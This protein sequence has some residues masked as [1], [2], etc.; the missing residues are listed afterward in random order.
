MNQAHELTRERVLEREGE[1]IRRVYNWMMAGLAV[2][3]GIAY[4]AAQSEAYKALI[5]SSTWIFYVLLGAELVM[6]FVLAG[7]I[8]RMSSGTAGVMFIIYS[9]LNGLTLA[10]IFW[11]YT[12]KSI[13]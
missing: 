13:A 10:T 9:M 5:L 12:Q 11:A 6:V 4:F 7:R 1:F 3:G 2:T 8:E